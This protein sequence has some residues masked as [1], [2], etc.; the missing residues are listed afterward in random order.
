MT[1]VA[2]PSLAD[3]AL[4]AQTESIDWMGRLLELEA[5]GVPMNAEV[6]PDEGL[7]VVLGIFPK[8]GS[9]L[10]TTY[11]CLFTTFTATTVGATSSVADNYTEP[12]DS[13]YVRVAIPST[14]WG[15]AAA[16]T[17]GRK[18]T[19]AQK[20]MPAANGNYGSAVN[21]Y[22]LANQSS[23]TGDKCLGAANFDEGAATP[24]AGD[25]LRVTPTW[26]LNN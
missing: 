8:G 4:L 6:A 22:W 17:G 7:D 2:L 5:D 21:G 13:A 18:V 15:S 3:V 19:C 23:S 10:S 26:Q 24:Q 20:S 9:N 16:G 14:D 12:T 11:L 1:A 25:V